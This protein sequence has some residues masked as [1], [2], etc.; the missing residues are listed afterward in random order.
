MNFLT[1]CYLPQYAASELL[2]NDCKGKQKVIGYEE[3]S[4]YF[5][6]DIIVD[7]FVILGRKSV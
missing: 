1:C 3:K 4:S 2:C 6:Y 7:N 5:S